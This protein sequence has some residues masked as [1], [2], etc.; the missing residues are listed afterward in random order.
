MLDVS[1]FC[2]PSVEIAFGNGQRAPVF[3]AGEAMVSVGSRGRTLSVSWPLIRRRRGDA[4]SR[5]A[6][7]MRGDSYFQRVCLLL[8]HPRRVG[9]S[10]SS[11]LV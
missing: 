2:V 10:H 3:I 4:V 7:E 5:I 9:I 1:G 11:S 8:H 6:R